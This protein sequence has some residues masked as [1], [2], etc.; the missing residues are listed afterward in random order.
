VLLR[1]RSAHFEPVQFVI[2][3]NKVADTHGFVA[4][5]VKIDLELASFVDGKLVL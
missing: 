1:D 2:F 4:E 3:G 5:M